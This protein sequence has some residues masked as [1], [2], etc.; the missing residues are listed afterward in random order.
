LARV[1]RHRGHRQPHRA[2]DND[3]IGRRKADDVLATR[4]DF[5]VTTNSGGALEVAKALRTRGG[6]LTAAHPLEVLAAPI[7]GVPLSWR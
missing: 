3:E 4:V 2:R 6:D 7:R 5:L 1:L